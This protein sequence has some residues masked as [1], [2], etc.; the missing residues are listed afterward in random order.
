MRVRHHA[1]TD[2]MF[3]WLLLGQWLFAI[4]LVLIRRPFSPVHVEMAV[5]FGAVIDLMPIVLIRVR[6]GWWATRHVVAGAQIL[7]SALLVTITDGRIETHFHVFGSLAFLAIYRDW[8]VLG[9]AT[10]LVFADHLVRGLAWPDSIYGGENYEWWRFLEHGGW[11]AFEDAF[12]LW[13]CAKSVTEMRAAAEREAALEQTNAASEALVDKRTRELAGA[14]ERYKALIENTEAIPFEY[15]RAARRFDY[16]APQAAR[17]FGC[18]PLELARGAIVGPLCHPD[19]LLRVK[20]ALAHPAKDPVDFRVCKRDG[21]VA[22]ARMW[23]SQLGGMVIDITRQKA[24]EDE[25][26]QA[27][28]LESVGRLAAGVAHE[29]NTPIQ[30]VGDSVEFIGGAVT[31]L[32]DLA[33]KQRAAIDDPAQ[34]GLARAAE[35]AIDL[36]YLVAKLPEALARAAEGTQRVAR[37]VRSM[38]IFAHPPRAEMAP[39]DLNLAIESTLTV[40]RNEYRYVADAELV[41][42]DLPKVTCH[43]GEINQVLLN[44]I[45]NAAH[46]I[47]ETKLR[48][49]IRVS[50]QRVGDDAVIEI[51]DTG[52]GIPDAVRDHVFEPF[53]TTKEVG[54]GTGQGLAIARSVVVDKHRGSL[55]FEPRSGGGTTFRIRIPIVPAVEARAA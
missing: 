21:K 6:P 22:H 14:V 20:R 50:S 5:G 42:G 23:V 51:A 27:Q 1:Q 9:T 31:D 35:E 47:G 48:G 26:R 55:T 44:L 32:L 29:I 40:A 11:V 49:T 16:I 15:D 18:S 30:F 24:L 52:T 8:R 28:K 37:I 2:R 45:V 43:A 19:D 7:W 4:A 36:P 17:L 25:L 53:F 46:A 10:V 13:A 33:T 38:K 41:L 12:L 34:A 3:R 39:V 54:R